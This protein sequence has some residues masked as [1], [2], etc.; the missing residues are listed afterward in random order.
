MGWSV[1]VE[2]ETLPK[3][4]ECISSC[5]NCDGNFYTGVMKLTGKQLRQMETEE[6]IAALDQLIKEVDKGDAGIFSNEWAME[7]DRHWSNGRETFDAYSKY[8]EVF[9]S[10]GFPPQFPFTDY[11]SFCGY[12]VRDRIRTDAFRFWLYYKAGYKITYEW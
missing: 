12:T 6:A 10:R 4:N 7:S 2:S 9:G 8:T 11:V 1:R 3:A 5:S